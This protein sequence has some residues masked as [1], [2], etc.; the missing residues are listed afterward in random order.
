MSCQVERIGDVCETKREMVM[1]WNSHSKLKFKNNPDSR[2]Q[3]NTLSSLQG[4]AMSRSKPCMG[5]WVDIKWRSRRNFFFLLRNTSSF[6]SA[7]CGVIGVS[8]DEDEHQGA[9]VVSLQTPTRS[10]SLLKKASQSSLTP[11]MVE[12]ILSCSIQRTTLDLIFRITP[13]FIHGLIFWRAA[14]YEWYIWKHPNRLRGSRSISVSIVIQNLT[15]PIPCSIFVC[16]FWNRSRS[17]DIRYMCRTNTSTP[18]I[19]CAVRCE[20]LVAKKEDPPL[21]IHVDEECTSRRCY[22]KLLEIEPP[23]Q[24][25]HP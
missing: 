19:S 10:S 3:R 13:T 12:N 11:S 21:S 16:V 7:N 2:C 24:G 15:D 17:M 1:T 22:R 23:A 8:S 6:A 25:P 20:H 14:G 4:R 9:S 5:Y 18:G